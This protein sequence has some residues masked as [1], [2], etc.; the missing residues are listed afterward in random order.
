MAIEGVET[1]LAQAT[2]PGAVTDLA[3]EHDQA[4]GQVQDLDQVRDK[5]QVQWIESKRQDNQA[6]AERVTRVLLV[7]TRAGRNLPGTVNAGS[8]VVPANQDQEHHGVQ[9]AGAVADQRAVVVV[10]AVAV[11]VDA[12]VVDVDVDLIWR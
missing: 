9:R 1:D 7:A 5:G 4:R 8:Q 3:L 12:V 2:G 6:V 10:D 11:V